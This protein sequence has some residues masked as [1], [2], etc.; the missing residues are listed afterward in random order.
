MGFGLPV[1]CHRAPPGSGPK[2][3]RRGRHRTWPTPGRR[4]RRRRA[5]TSNECARSPWPQ[6]IQ[7]ASRGRGCWRAVAETWRG[8]REGLEKG[9]SA[10]RLEMI[11]RRDF[12]WSAARVG[13]PPP[14]P[15]CCQGAG[16]GLKT[17]PDGATLDEEGDNSTK[18]MFQTGRQ[19][20]PRP[21]YACFRDGQIRW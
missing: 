21:S 13:P 3:M 18:S 19:S 2:A 16:V 11:C 1:A 20:C 7:K 8:G 4:T 5:E 12:W 15:S 17:A 9:L 6:V 14:R 10:C